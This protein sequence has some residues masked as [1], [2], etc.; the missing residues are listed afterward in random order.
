MRHRVSKWAQTAAGWSDAKT[1]FMV[2]RSI[3]S[4]RSCVS[5]GAGGG[6]LQPR[7]GP[8]KQLRQA[9]HH[10][11]RFGRRDDAIGRAQATLTALQ[12]LLFVHADLDVDPPTV[13]G[14]VLGEVL[15]QLVAL[16]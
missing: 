9:G 6:G 3:G 2:V 13:L 5:V 7:M 12:R 15:A 16:P 10:P 4:V 8:A 1:G 11:L 14:E